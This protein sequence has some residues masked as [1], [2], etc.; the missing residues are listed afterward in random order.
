MEL[1]SEITEKVLGI[2]SEHAEKV[3]YDLRKAA[4]IILFNVEGKIAVLH[5]KNSNYHK[6][7]GGGV[8]LG[9]DIETALKREV[10]EEVGAN[11]SIAGEIGITIEYRDQQHL[12]QLSYCYY[13]FVEGE[14]F[15]PSF[16]EKEKDDGFSLLWM[17]PQTAIEALK[18]DKPS[19]YSG[20]F[21][22]YRDMSIL[23][24][25]EQLTKRILTDYKEKFKKW[26]N[27]KVKSTL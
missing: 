10:I 4:R 9:E 2:E 20:R 15:L 23:L 27:E 7:P 6:L 17:N 5:V 12:L 19:N 1:I 18:N 3:R 11:A 14:I 26:L 25:A 16:T 22:H 24:K 13:G 21:I 8:E